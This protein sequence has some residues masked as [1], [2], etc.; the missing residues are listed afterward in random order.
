MRYFLLPAI[1]LIFSTPMQASEPVVH[2]VLSFSRGKI[3][4]NRPMSQAAVVMPMVS[5][6]KCQE[7]GAIATTRN[8]EEIRTFFWCIDGGIQ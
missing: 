5:M 4:V 3:K 1:L 7:E 2:L 8:K 6:D